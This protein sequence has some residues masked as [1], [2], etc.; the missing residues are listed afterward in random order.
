MISLRGVSLTY[1]N[2]VRALD[3]VSLE[4]AKGDFVFLV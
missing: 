2:G 4:I 3:H 1:P